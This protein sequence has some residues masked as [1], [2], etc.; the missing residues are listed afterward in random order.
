[1]LANLLRQLGVRRAEVGE[2]GAAGVVG[3]RRRRRSLVEVARARERLRGQPRADDPSIALDQTA[4]RLAREH[5]LGEAGEERRQREPEAERQ[6]D[7]G[8]GGGLE[9]AH[10]CASPSTIGP[11]VSAGKTT[12]PGVSTIT[13]NS[14]AAKVGPSVRN[15]PA[16][17]GAARLPASEPP[18]ASAAS[19]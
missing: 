8:D 2:G 7:A 11:S 4:V 16:E 13:P 12:N 3:R 5:E 14:R 1:A 10:Q 15:V 19:S 6:A 17:T 9:V 18:I